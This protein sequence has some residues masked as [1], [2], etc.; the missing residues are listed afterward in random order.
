MV[1]KATQVL[2]TLVLTVLGSGCS[3][4]ATTP[5]ADQNFLSD[6]YVFDPWASSEGLEIAVH[7]RDGETRFL[8]RGRPGT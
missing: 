3:S 1:G 6:D 2:V 8:T 5:A 7:S 4:Q